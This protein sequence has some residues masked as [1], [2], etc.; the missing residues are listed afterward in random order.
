M[1]MSILVLWAKTASVTDIT[2]Q[3]YYVGKDVTSTLP[4][5]SAT[6]TVTGI[7]QYSGDNLLSGT[8]DVDFFHKRQLVAHWLITYVLSS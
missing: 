1:P 2:H 4:T 3:S 7:S 5:D 8:F 6:Y